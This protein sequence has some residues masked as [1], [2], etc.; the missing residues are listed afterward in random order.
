MPITIAQNGRHGWTHVSVWLPLVLG[1]LCIPAFIVWEAYAKHPMMPFKV[2]H[3]LHSYLFYN[4]LPYPFA[5]FL[6]L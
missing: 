3:L 2:R 1:G 4:F 6:W 5:L